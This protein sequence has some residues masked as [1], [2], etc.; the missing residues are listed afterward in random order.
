MAT[1]D[2]LDQ[3]LYVLVQTYARQRHS[4]AASELSR[5]GPERKDSVHDPQGD[6]RDDDA[7]SDAGTGESQSLPIVAVL[8]YISS[9]HFINSNTT[10]LGFTLA[11]FQVAIEFFLLR[12]AHVASCR[13]CQQQSQ[14]DASIAVDGDA[15]AVCTQGIGP[16]KVEAAHARNVRVHAQFLARVAK[17]QDTDDGVSTS[18]DSATAALTILGA[19]SSGEDTDAYSGSESE[20]E[21]ES[22]AV[23]QAPSVTTVSLPA[24]SS[25]NRDDR[26]SVV[27]MSAGERFFAAVTSDGALYT[28]GDRSGGRLGFAASAGDP[29]RVVSPQRVAGLSRSHVLHVACGAFHALATDVNGHVFAWGTNA[30]G[31]LGFVAPALAT[32]TPRV[33]VSPTL[34]TGLCGTYVSAVACGAYHSLALASTGRVF[35]WGCA[36]FGKL[37]RATETF[38]DAVVRLLSPR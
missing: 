26:R 25:S 9:Y 12:A 23:D 34:V 1:D 31:Q 32:P 18:T 35:S 17:T 19:W 27:D 30:V 16:S 13:D 5:L 3:L 28:W 10:A 24:P 38:A 4:A 29:R 14:L 6:S 20:S 22:H 7:R 11:N 15:A 33:I 2:I 36:R 8:Q 21:S 37:G